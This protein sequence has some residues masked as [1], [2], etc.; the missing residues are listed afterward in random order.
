MTVLLFPQLDINAN[1]YRRF[2][3]L[4]EKFPDVKTT[5]AVGGWAEGGKKYS[6]MV[7]VKERRETFIRSVV[8][9]CRRAVCPKRLMLS[10][11]QL[12]KS[13]EMFFSFSWTFASFTI[14]DLDLTTLIIMETSLKTFT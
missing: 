7:S 13:T 12:S 4:K 10:Y 3:A 14:Q 2:V 9:E 6:Q 5:I 1:G 11:L 8:R